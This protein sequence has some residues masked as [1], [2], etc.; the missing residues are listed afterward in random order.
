MSETILDGRNLIDAEIKAF[1]DG[2]RMF[3]YNTD[4]P[5][6]KELE[7]YPVIINRNKGKRK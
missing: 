1:D 7:Q 2:L 4:F 5:S 3:L 6:G